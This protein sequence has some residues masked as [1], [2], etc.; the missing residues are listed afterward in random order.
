MKLTD[1]LCYKKDIELVAVQFG[2][3]RNKIR[4]VEIN[5]SSNG[6]WDGLLQREN[7]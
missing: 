3:Q 2:E 6:S 5:C 1:D 4:L 7:Y